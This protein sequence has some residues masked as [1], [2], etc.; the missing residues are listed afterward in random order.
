VAIGLEKWIERA[1][2]YYRVILDK[3]EENPVSNKMKL[4][5]VR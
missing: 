1:S 3:L 5:L 4:I 2:I